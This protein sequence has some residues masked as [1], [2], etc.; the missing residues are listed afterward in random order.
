VRRALE[1][2]TYH[3]LQ[4]FWEHESGTSVRDWR[5]GSHAVRDVTR[6]GS[7]LGLLRE[8]A[9]RFDGRSRQRT[10]CLLLDILHLVWE[11]GHPDTLLDEPMRRAALLLKQRA[12]EPLSMRDISSAL[13]LGPVQFTRRFR[14]CHGCNPIEF[15]TRERL[16]K[17]RRLLIETDLPLSEIAARCGYS[18]GFYLSHTWKK[19][20]G[21]TPG[22][23]RKL[24]RV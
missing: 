7:T 3:V 23:F 4:F 22:G 15:L 5:V 17:A 21:S 14:A 24:H 18:S 12:T 11:A 13:G 9:S 16:E 20:I 19:H 8:E 6:L 1:P 2:L 10:Q